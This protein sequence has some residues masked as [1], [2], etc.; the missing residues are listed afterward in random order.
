MRRHTDWEFGDGDQRSYTDEEIVRLAEG[1]S[2]L[3]AHEMPVMMTRADRWAFVLVL[4][5]LAGVLVLAWL[6]VW[7]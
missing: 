3:L 7:S 6:M 5:L 1:R 4:T 2:D